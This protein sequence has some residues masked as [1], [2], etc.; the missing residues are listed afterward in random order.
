MKYSLKQ[1]PNQIQLTIQLPLTDLA[2]AA[3]QRKA[4]LQA[5]SAKLIQKYQWQVAREPQIK[6]V[7]ENSGILEILCTVDLLPEMI[8]P[9][10]MDLQIEAPELAL[11]QE[12]DLMERIQALQI[13]F[14]ETKPS[15]TA[16]DW[17]DLVRI[18]WIGICQNDLI[19]LSPKAGFFMLLHQE[20]WASPLAATLIGAQA[21]DS[22]I[23]TETLPQDHPYL[24]WRG[25]SAE[26]HIYV[27]SV[28]NL[29]V[30]PHQYLAQAAGLG[31]DFDTLLSH[32]H[33]EIRDQN[34]TRWRQN[35]QQRLMKQILKSCQGKV[36]E[37]WI[38]A[39]LAAW[40][41]ESDATQLV[42]MQDHL[43]IASAFLKA[44]QKNWQVHSYLA[45]KIKQD[46]SFQLLLNSLAERNPDGLKEAEITQT[47][48]AVGAPLNMNSELVWNALQRDGQTQLFLNQ[49]RLEKASRWLLKQAQIRCGE[50]ILP[51]SSGFSQKS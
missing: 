40:W 33:Q 18:D 19:P 39:G 50:Q 44:G 23:Y 38:E 27:E 8:V 49:I 37:Y 7:R 42:E 28:Q 47:L 15:Q 45:Q 17:G 41:Q 46:L 13:R 35:I 51:L 9:E 2:Q 11:P 31:S 20:P 34:Q 3:D 21:G 26:Y 29:T 10:N 4:Q 16:A 25:Q 14:G 43:P 30:P 24:P 5:A 6:T 1:V 22:R 32:L 36:P 48:E 12:Q